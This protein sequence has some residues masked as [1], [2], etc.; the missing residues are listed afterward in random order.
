MNLNA[1]QFWN[2]ERGYYDGSKNESMG[3][4]AAYGDFLSGARGGSVIPP[5]EF[6]SPFNYIPSYGSSVSFQFSN[7]IIPFGDGYS[8]VSPA[9]MNNCIINYIKTL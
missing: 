9:L 1:G 2:L 3:G 6:E 7:N 4:Y 8:Q 5:F